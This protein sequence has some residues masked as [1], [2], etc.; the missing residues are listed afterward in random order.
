MAKKI[1][2]SIGVCSAKGGVGKTITALNLA[3]TFYKMGKK[4]LIIDMDLSGGG[5]AVALNKP[6]EK[7]IDDMVLDME[8]NRYNSLND[9]VTKYNENIDF[10]ASPKDPREVGKIDAAYIDLILDRAVLNY[11]VV[12]VDT[13]HIINELNLVLLERLDHI[14][15]ITTNDPFDI[16]NLKSLL[17]IFHDIEYTNYKILLNQSR[18]PLKNYFSLYDI[19]NILK[20]NIDYS[21][22]AKFYIKNIDDYIMNGQ[23]VTLDNRMEKAFPEESTTFLQ[24]ATDFLADKEEKSNEE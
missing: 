15:F 14:L 21:L 9:Y 22:S 7:S 3:G 18:E 5:I 17:S 2:K 19:K 11:D 6:V 20:D 24:M 1:G 12:I 13:N 4:V 10:L 23:I 8:N 16:K